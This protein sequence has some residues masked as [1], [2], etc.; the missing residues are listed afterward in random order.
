MSG[1]QHVDTIMEIYDDL[2]KDL[3][4]RVGKM[5]IKQQDKKL[6]YSMVMQAISRKA[7]EESQKHQT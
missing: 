7:Y 4:I 3:W 1:R 2:M 6:V 5:N